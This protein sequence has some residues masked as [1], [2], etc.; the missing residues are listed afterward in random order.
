MYKIT[1]FFNSNS[2][3]FSVEHLSEKT[4]STFDEWYKTRKDKTFTFDIVNP[5]YPL[6]KII[7]PRNNISFYIIEKQ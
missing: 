3:N 4:S 5:N 2:N 1:I 7:V 6:K